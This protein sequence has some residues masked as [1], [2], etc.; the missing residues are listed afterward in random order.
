MRHFLSRRACDHISFERFSDAR[1]RDSADDRRVHAGAPLR[2]RQQTGD[3][4]VPCR[5]GP[6]YA[7][8]AEQVHAAVLRLLHRHL[9]DNQAV[10]REAEKTVFDHFKIRLFQRL[11][12]FVFSYFLIFEDFRHILILLFLALFHIHLLFVLLILHN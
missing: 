9:S 12:S 10:F 11:L 5:I 4:R 6:F 1:S 2:V 3:R 8:R 7:D